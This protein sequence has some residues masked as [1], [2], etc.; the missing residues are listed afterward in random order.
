MNTG[1]QK[2]EEL[3]A[4]ARRD[5]PNSAQLQSLTARLAPMTGPLPLPDPSVMGPG[6]M[7]GGGAKL[8]GFAAAK[9]VTLA[10][11]TAVGVGL[12]GL[13]LR[14]RSPSPSPR[15]EQIQTVT[16]PPQFAESAVDTTTGVATGGT[17]RATSE[18]S[19]GETPE[20]ALDSPE[21][22]RTSEP[23][24]SPVRRASP[25]RRIARI[26]E[27]SGGSA[28]LGSGAA[29]V[30]DPELSEAALLEQARARVSR[31]PTLALELADEH[32]ARFAAGSLA[33]EREVIAIEALL[34]LGRRDDAL[35]RAQE[36]RRSFPASAY[37]QKLE[38]VFEHVAPAP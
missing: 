14:N 28:G 9:V 24:R 1:P 6:A 16:S 25:V 33:Q 11:V 23:G 20:S 13:A 2:L 29:V 26:G 22:S 15:A 35:R 37:L 10:T 34:R 3:L 38:A 7:A 31:N 12:G 36:F 5:L 30:T 18:G 32:R 19:A 4:A 17:T 27:R 21:A 8:F